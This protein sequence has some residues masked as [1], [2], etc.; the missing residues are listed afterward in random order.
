MAAVSRA[1]KDLRTRHPD[2]PIM[3]RGA[4]VSRSLPSEHSGMRV[5]ER[6]DES[7]QAVEELL[8]VPLPVPSM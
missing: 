5:L 2:I 7:V 4:A 8:S 6:I 1:V 3:L